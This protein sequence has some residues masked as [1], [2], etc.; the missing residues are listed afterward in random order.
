[1]IT[2]Y[3]CVTGR[4]DDLVWPLEAQAVN[5]PQVRYIFFV[6]NVPEGHIWEMAKARGW[7]FQELAWKHE[8]PTRSARFHKINPD[9]VLPEDTEISIWID[10]SQ[11]FKDTIHPRR[12]ATKATEK[13][14]IATFR[15]PLRRCVYE[16]AKACVQREK[17]DPEVIRSQMARYREQLYPRNNGMVETACVIRR[18]DKLATRFCEAWWHEISTGSRRD[19]LSFNFVH[20][21]LGIPYGTIPGHREDSPFFNFQHHRHMRRNVKR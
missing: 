18:H 9:L 5:D 11:Q 14:S 6:D 13:V 21:R 10:G 8:D 4:Y 15:H 3:T 17:D 7:Q 2:V 19:Q 12:L 16:E 20:W 1:M